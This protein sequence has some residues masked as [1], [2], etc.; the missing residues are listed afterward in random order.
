MK[1]I[2]RGLSL[3]LVMVMLISSVA[4]GL[5]NK[6]IMAEVPK[7]ETL[8]SVPSATYPIHFYVPETIYLTPNLNLATTFKYYVDSS[9]GTSPMLDNSKDKTSGNV[10]FY[11]ADASSISIACAGAA[12]TMGA[13]TGTTT[14]DTSIT[15]GTL[16]LGVSQA[17]TQTLTWTAT[18]IVNGVQ[19]TAKAYTV[20][21]A[22]R[23]EP[24][25]AA[26][27]T[28]SNDGLVSAAMADLQGFA[29]LS[30]IQGYADGGLRTFNQSGTSV[31]PLLGVV[32]AP[33]GN[34][35]YSDWLGGSS[36]GVNYGDWEGA[37]DAITLVR[38]SPIGTLA[39]D[40]SRYTNIN[41][42]PNLTCGLVITNT[43]QMDQLNFYMSNYD[44]GTTYLTNADY[45]SSGD[46]NNAFRDNG[47]QG[48]AFL[49]DATTNQGVSSGIKYGGQTGVNVYSVP[50]S[51]TGIYNM[52]LKAASWAKNTYLFT[53]EWN[54]IVFNIGVTVTKYSKA[55]LRAEIRHYIN[56]GL[57]QSDYAMLKWATYA[58][59]I[60]DAAASLG[61]PS[62]GPIT[63][64]IA[65]AYAALVRAQLTANVKHIFS[66]G[67]TT[68]IETISFL[69]G[70][71]LNIGPNNY[72]G[73]TIATADGMSTSIAP[74]TLNKVIA[75]GTQNY[76]YNANTYTVNY[77][78]NGGEGGSTPI[79]THTY[80]TSLDLRLNAFIKTGYTFAGWATSAEGTVVYTNGQS[81]MNLTSTAGATIE[82]YA[83]WK[84]I[85]SFDSN[86]GTDVLPI[87]VIQGTSV[88][89]PTDPTRPGYSFSGWYYDIFFT[90]AVSWPIVLSQSVTVYA[91][92]T[93]EQNT[94][95][96]NSNGGT[97]VTAIGAYV[98]HKV[99]Q[100]SP[101]TRE[102][103]TFIGW[104]RDEGTLLNSVQWPYVM[105]ESSVT[106]YAKWTPNNITITYNSDGGNAVADLT[107][108]ADSPITAPTSP[109]KF[110]FTFAG[111]TLN[112]DPY[113]I[114][115][116][117]TQ[118]ITLV[119]TW[120]VMERA[121][122][123][124]LKTYKKVN[125]VFIP[126]TKARAGDTVYVFLTEK[127]N[128][129]CGSSKYV[130]MYDTSF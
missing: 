49:G 34:Q 129:Y 88:E 128:F 29:Y 3:L 81:V 87:S 75:S 14:I 58:Q 111:W 69:S 95:S 38:N 65:T 92:W 21:Y 94:V 64:T 121:A 39:V 47:A 98:L 74:Q 73:Y 53:D 57:Q 36:G 42:I 22:P 55:D 7:A 68:E 13:N 89:K 17:E 33:N 19:L 59:A 45:T 105:G 115:T 116:M 102:G 27:R 46:Q 71:S 119:A 109:E 63:S 90:Q 79:T 96:F 48:V 112:G 117:P 125:D 54:C 10:Y 130:I 80:N 77:N 70:E 82:L 8:A 52:R 126:I 106:F 12:V 2:K 67:K 91:K 26:A 9:N 28:Y 118:N 23:V 76:R 11:C 31:T 16:E 120:T 18:Y 99:N 104:Y 5:G 1:N 108:L 72:E 41:Q 51:G 113:T 124:E 62:T 25:G 43:N 127:T 85:L 32:T 78:I 15:A 107:A 35:T 100:P 40:T 61:N 30:G 83:I 110:G 37:D 114:S 123:T 24:I 86:N 66:S 101:P 4:V 122:Q 44:A 50:L 97:P 103:Y 6:T 84:A 20:C 56:L 93:Y 60:S